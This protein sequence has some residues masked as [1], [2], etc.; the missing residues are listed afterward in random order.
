MSSRYRNAPLP[1]LNPVAQTGKDQAPSEVYLPDD[2]LVAAVNVALM[3]GRPLLVTGEPGCGKTRLAYHLASE[4]GL[5][6]PLRFDTKSDSDAKDLFYTYDAIAHFH[7]AQVSGKPDP[8]PH[9]RLNALGRAVLLTHPKDSL[10]ETGLDRLL[11]DPSSASDAADAAAPCQSVVLIDEIDKAPRD[12]PNDILNEVEHLCFRI[13][14][15]GRQDKALAVAPEPSLRPILILTSNSE[16]NLPD[17]FLRRCIYYDIRFPDDPRRLWNIVEAHLVGAAATRRAQF[18]EAL[19]LFAALRADQAGLRKK[20]GTAELLDWLRVLDRELEPTQGL[21]AQSERVRRSLGA[22]IKNQEDHQIAKKELD[23][24][25]QP[26]A[27][28]RA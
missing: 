4:L 11:D 18:S 7:A 12:F 17:A 14:E 20:P 21:A 26:V 2:G 27:P 3:L 25:F 8:L 10:T 5:E 19:D 15:L 16:K 23:R 24:R 6:A 28:P 22:L 9:L 1:P 13:P